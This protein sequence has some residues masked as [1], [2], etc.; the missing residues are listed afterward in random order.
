[1]VGTTFTVPQG[2]TVEKIEITMS[3]AVQF[4]APGIVYFEGNPYGNMTATGSVVTITPC[5]E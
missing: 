2:Y 4:V 3:E 5:R 1:M